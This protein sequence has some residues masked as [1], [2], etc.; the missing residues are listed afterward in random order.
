MTARDFDPRHPTRHSGFSLVEVVIA[1]GIFAIAVVGI[2]GLLPSLARQAAESS[3]TIAAQRLPEPVRIEFE[4]LAASAGFDSLAAAVPV[5]GAPLQDGFELVGARD[6]LRV[7]VANPGFTTGT[8]VLPQSERYFYI[9][10]WRFDQAPLSYD[11]GASVLALH[12]RV[13]WPYFNPG[14]TRATPL[15]DRN[16]FTFTVTLKR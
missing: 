8:S 7:L 13:S 1:V 3:D 14:S 10:A 15:A 16:Q 9:E 4:R 11:P 5:M 2:L 12:I 6:G